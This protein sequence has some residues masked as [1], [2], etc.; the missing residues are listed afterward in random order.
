MMEIIFKCLEKVAAIDPNKEK[1]PNPEWVG[2]FVCQMTG[3]A[4]EGK[5]FS[6]GKKRYALKSR[7]CWLSGE[8]LVKKHYRVYCFS[9]RYDNVP[10][11]RAMNPDSRSKWQQVCAKTGAPILGPY[12][13][14]IGKLWLKKEFKC[15]KCGTVLAETYAV[16]N[17]L[18]YLKDCLD[19]MD[20]E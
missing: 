12:V 15:N 6:L 17:G 3:Q 1:D 18:P 7:V 10:I 2:K 20:C 4:I 8:P 19:E 11:Y 13:K 16:K 5:H 9:R 14:A